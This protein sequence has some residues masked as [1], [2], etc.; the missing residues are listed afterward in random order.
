[1]VTCALARVPSP[2]RSV[3]IIPFTTIADATKLTI[4]GTC[5]AHQAAHS[6]LCAR[7]LLR[8]RSMARRRDN[9]ST[10]SERRRTAIYFA[11][12]ET[13]ELKVEVSTAKEYLT[14]TG[15]RPRSYAASDATIL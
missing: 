8:M 7:M 3:R 2:P 1:M 14:D 6:G 5:R 9:N 4:S 11:P 10:I 12:H 15:Q 13:F